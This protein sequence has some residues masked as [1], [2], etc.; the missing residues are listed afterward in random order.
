MRGVTVEGVLRGRVLRE[1]NPA[2]EYGGR[3]TE[4]GGVL[5]KEYWG[6]STEGVLR[7]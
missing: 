6:R 5:G 3:S 4:E 2:Y 1:E 7:L